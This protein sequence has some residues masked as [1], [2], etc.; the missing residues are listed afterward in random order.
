MS[1]DYRAG[2]LQ[3]DLEVH[4]CHVSMVNRKLARKDSI[5]EALQIMQSWN[6]T[7]YLTIFMTDFN[8]EEIR[9]IEET[10]PGMRSNFEVL[11]T[12]SYNR[13]TKV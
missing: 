12:L 6:S 8:E 10:F 2:N 7:W 9:A 11:S 1:P 4:V 5:K 13:Y 3:K